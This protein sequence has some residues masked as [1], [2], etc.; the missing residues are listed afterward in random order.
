MFNPTDYINYTVIIIAFILSCLLLFNKQTPFYLKTFAPFIFIDSIVGLITI[1][2]ANKGIHTIWVVNFVCLAEVCFFIWILRCFIA[3]VRVKKYATLSIMVLPVLTIL[4][5]F[6]LQGLND[7]HSITYSID[8]LVL[9]S[10]CIYYFYELFKASY[11]VQ[12]ITDPS[13]WICSGVLLYFCISFPM[14]VTLNL[15]KEFPYKLGQVIQIISN[16]INIIL[17]IM[18]SIAFICEKRYRKI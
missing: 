10:L 14:Y 1:Y 8:C 6:F 5:I 17:Y 13:F 4:N 16:S 3:N 18:L 7:F 9:I 2:M 12:L 11:S 15:M